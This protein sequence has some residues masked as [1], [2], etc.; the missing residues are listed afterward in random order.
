[1]KGHLFYDAG[2]GWHTP[3]NGIPS[4]AIVNGKEVSYVVRDNFHLRHSV[5][6]GLNLLKPFPA[7]IDWGYKLDR[8]KKTGE[9]A[10]EFHIAM[11]AAW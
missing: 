10:S 11:N 1:M 4:P 6:F 5:G 7:K 8:K 2:A 9:S 3:K